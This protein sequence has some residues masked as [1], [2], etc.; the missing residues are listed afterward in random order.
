MPTDPS[1]ARADD[2]VCPACGTDVPD[3]KFCASCGVPLAAVGAGGRLRLNTYAAA[4]REHVLR[5]WVTTALFPQLPRGSRAAYRMGLIL[6]AAAAEGFAVL[7]WLVPV[8]VTSILGLPVLYVAYLRDI[9]MCRSVRGWHLA[10]AAVVALGLGV[11]WELVTGPMVEDA[12][13]AEMGG[14]MS[15][16]QLLWCGVAIPIT[17]AFVLVAPAALV[18]VLNRSGRDALDGFTAGAVGA[19]LVNAAATATFLAPQLT[20]GP[21]A[22]GQPIGS[23]LAEVMVEG[24][25]WPLGSAAAGG[26]FGLALWFTP[27]A[28]ASRRYRKIVVLPAAVLG[29]VAFAIAMGFVD[30]APVP[31][32]VYLALQLPIALAAVLAI[33]TGITDALLHEA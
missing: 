3:Q 7:G 30:V 15:V 26:L 8:I 20:S 24:V 1:P 32:N 6:L 4:S 23:L 33:R 13:Y 11:A 22:G 17:F 9:A 19:T 5:P 29:A 31:M 18:R 28:N 21:V 12:Y 16:G 10:L 2:V 27:R 14:E 25:A